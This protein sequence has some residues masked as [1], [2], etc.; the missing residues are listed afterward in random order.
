MRES[1]KQIKIAVMVA[2]VVFSIVGWYLNDFS[3][4]VQ[5]THRKAALCD[6]LHCDDLVVAAAKI[7]QL[8]LPA[9]NAITK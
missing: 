7:E 2:A 1:N 9:V 3:R 5:E 6:Q 4:Y 8:K